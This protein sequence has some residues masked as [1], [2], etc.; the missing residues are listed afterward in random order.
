MS[1]LLRPNNCSFVLEQ[2]AFERILFASSLGC[3][4]HHGCETV[5]PTI[6]AGFS[7]NTVELV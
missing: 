2:M 5:Q 3:F 4:S 6:Q 1:E 7:P